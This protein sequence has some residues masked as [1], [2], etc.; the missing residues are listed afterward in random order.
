MK[1]GFALEYSLGHIT[2]ADNLKR[3]LKDDSSVEPVYIDLPFDGIDAPWARL[4]GIRG[5]WSARA[6]AAAYLALSPHKKTL[7]AVLFHTQVTSL[8]SA[9]FM[10]SVPSVISLDATPLQYDAMGSFYGHNPSAN[11][12]LENWKKGLNIKAFHAARHLVTWSEWAKASLVADYQVPADKVTVI[13]PG[14]DTKNWDFTQHTKDSRPGQTKLLFVGGDFPR[15]GGDTLLAA[16]R[17]LPADLGI[18]LDIVTKDQP[19]I[20]GCGNVRVHNGLKPNSKPLMDLFANAHV[21]V[22]PT[23]GDCLP[24]AV[25]EAL[26]AGLPVITSDV[27]AL[28]EAVTDNITGLV[29]PPDDVE[30]LAKAITYLAGHPDE[31]QKMSTAARAVGLERFDAVTN[32][33]RLVQVVKSV[34]K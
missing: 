20:A 34:A 18:E 27:G 5:N 30:A 24:L 7:D 16:M 12:S 8:L 25:M 21:F 9:G 15:K 22:F 29:V 26:T 19:D 23:R 4:P 33:R 10:K 32:Y 17:S 11:S 31:R 13:P 3:V 1:L 2:H 6:S 14:I 28:S